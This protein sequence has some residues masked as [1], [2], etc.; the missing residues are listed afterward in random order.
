MSRCIAK[1]ATTKVRARSE[2]RQLCHILPHRTLTHCRML[3]DCAVTWDAPAANLQER[4][5]ANCIPAVSANGALFGIMPTGMAPS[6]PLQALNTGVQSRFLRW[7][8]LYEATLGT[9]HYSGSRWCRRWQRRSHLEGLERQHLVRAHSSSAGYAAYRHTATQE[10]DLLPNAGSAHYHANP[11]ECGQVRTSAPHARSTD[12]F[13]RTAWRHLAN[14]SGMR[15]ELTALQFDRCR[16][17]QYNEYSSSQP[18]YPPTNP[19][20]CSRDRKCP[21]SPLAHMY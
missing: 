9:A 8:N 7:K 20:E 17:V 10:A 12:D 15:G 19:C 5:A 4:T 16:C 18:T 14:C 11:A 13:S 3:A 1:W 2:L 21:L 6:S